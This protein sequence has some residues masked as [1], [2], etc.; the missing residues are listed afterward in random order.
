MS[1]LVNQQGYWEHGFSI[2][3]VKQRAFLSLVLR[4]LLSRKTGY[5]MVAT[6]MAR[7]LASVLRTPVRS[8]GAISW[9][10]VSICATALV[11]G[12]LPAVVRL[13][14]RCPVHTVR[15]S[16]VTVSLMV[17]TISSRGYCFAL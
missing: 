10:R 3:S 12:R 9:C 13:A 16:I 4:S 17:T 8:T 6:T 15:S 14:Y 5:H 2:A 1:K 11:T 7:R